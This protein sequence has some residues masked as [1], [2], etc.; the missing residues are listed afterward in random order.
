MGED[1]GKPQ[2]NEE[3]PAQP[4]HSCRRAKRQREY[5][6]HRPT[7]AFR[8]L[9]TAPLQ[10]HVILEEDETGNKVGEVKSYYT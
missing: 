10:W 8:Q 5:N 2:A 9:A 7:L 4:Q 3:R 1:T 6:A